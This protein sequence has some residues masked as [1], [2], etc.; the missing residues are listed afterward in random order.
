MRPR[1]ADVMSLSAKLEALKK[2]RPTQARAGDH[3]TGKRGLPRWAWIVFGLLLAGAGTLAVVE[4]F[5]W[6]KVPPALVGTWQ[7]QEGSL[8]G[9]TFDFSRDGALRMRHKNADVKW[10]VSVN[11]KTLLMTTRSAHTGAES[12]Q[13]GTIQELTPNALVL[14]L[15]KGEVLKMVRRQ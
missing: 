7:V 11:G 1:M 15:E 14:E 12:T 8:S 10:R 2:R 6:N 3:K 4:F 13:R 5:I 9:G